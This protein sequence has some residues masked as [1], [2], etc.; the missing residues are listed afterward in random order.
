MTKGICGANF[1]V[2]IYD[3]LSHLIAFFPIALAMGYTLMPAT[4]ARV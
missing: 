3:S 4:R 2:A 1:A